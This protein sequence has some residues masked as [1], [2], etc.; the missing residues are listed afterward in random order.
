MV[1]VCGRK[2]FSSHDM[3]HAVYI[4]VVRRKVRV[5]TSRSDVIP[6]LRRNVR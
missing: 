4:V 2:G 1:G 6:F 5:E 3:V